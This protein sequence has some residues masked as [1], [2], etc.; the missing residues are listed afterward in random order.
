MRRSPLACRQ[1]SLMSLPLELE[2]RRA[3]IRQRHV[4]TMIVRM[5]WTTPVAAARR[6]RKRWFHLLE[7]VE[8]QV[9]GGGARSAVGSSAVNAS[10]H[11]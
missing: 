1:A 7:Q 5:T 11:V 4:A 8:G 10:E 6:C 3:N 2:D 9:G